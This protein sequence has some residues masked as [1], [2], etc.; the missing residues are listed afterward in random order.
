MGSLK[1][2]GLAGSIPRA[3]ATGDEVANW[4]DRVMSDRNIMRVMGSF[5]PRGQ[6]AGMD[7][8]IGVLLTWGGGAFKHLYAHH[9]REAVM[10][11]SSHGWI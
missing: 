1:L 4:V 10:A 2:M 8:Y 9:L 5:R 7:G 11:E 6:V 3:R